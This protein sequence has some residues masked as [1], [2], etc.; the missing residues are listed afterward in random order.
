MQTAM[1]YNVA[2]V[3]LCVLMIFSM[4]LRGLVRGLSS[5]LY[6][7][8]TAFLII[9]GLL[10]MAAN[11][12][13]PI[14]S[15]SAHNA[16]YQEL[17][18][19][20]SL[21]VRNFTPLLFL[22]YVFA[23]LDIWHKIKESFYVKVGLYGP[24][25][26]V[27]L[28]IL[29]NHF[30]GFI[31]TLDS[32][33]NMLHGRYEG[34]IYI[35]VL[36]YVVATSIMVFIHRKA[37]DFRKAI[38]LELFFPVNILAV[39]IQYNYPNMRIELFVASVMMVL[40]ALSVLRPEERIGHD[41]KLFSG[42]AFVEDVRKCVHTKKSVSIMLGN[43]ININNIL[44][45]VGQEAFTEFS[46]LLGKTTLKLGKSLKISMKE[47]YLERGT[48]AI[49][50]DHGEKEKLVEY[51]ER[52]LALMTDSIEEKKTGLE[53]EV[54]SV[55][56][57]FPE[58]ISNPDELITFTKRFQDIIPNE[59]G[60]VLISNHIGS[61]DFTIKSN[62]DSIIS[63]AIKNNYL[64]MY[65]QP[66]Y[67]ISEDR[68]LSSEA[69][70]RM[71]DPEYGFISPAFFIEAAEKSGA[72]HVIGNFV[73]E[74]VA[75][76]IHDSRIT[77]MGVDYV[78]INLSAVQCVEPLLIKKVNSIIDKY[79]LDHSSVNLEITETA[80]D[81]NHKMAYSNIV[82][83]HNSGYSFALDDYG[84]GYASIKKIV[85]FPFDIVKIDKSLADM[86]NE[87]NMYKVIASTVNTLKKLDKKILVEGV[88]DEETFKVFK[89]LGCDY[90]QGY[91]FSRPL[92]E[93][94]YLKFIKE[95]QAGYFRL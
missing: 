19:S 63:R 13:G 52:F 20:I 67:S 95:H 50:V 78:E 79:Q 29:T 31:F 81:S 28:L 53:I 33:G 55:I 58:D 14:I 84:T 72:I 61:K 39:F 54:R 91:Y 89:E 16:T 74:A 68:F 82:G 88:E 46:N 49:M 48:F 15:G 4:F 87:E 43:V 9:S 38:V 25:A 75:K 65:Y 10:D 23:G 32:K 83:L 59:P 18:G 62:I 8:F 37:I 6:I 71:M 44:S 36:Y 80:M 66:I 93:A 77:D 40:V 73:L 90:I 45:V 57:D 92:P 3:I 34:I 1:Y 41:I 24:Y 12:Y 60:I 64:S 2:A 30:T 86:I 94:E 5:K 85:A 56:V 42:A 27:A 47:Y 70:I 21:L 76:F 51:S 17:L 35:V 69:L 26:V 11:I 22:L 7:I